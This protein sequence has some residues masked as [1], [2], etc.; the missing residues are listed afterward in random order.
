M[1]GNLTVEFYNKR[2][3]TEIVI[4]IVSKLAENFTKYNSKYTIFS[5]TFFSAETQNKITFHI[6]TK[7]NSNYNNV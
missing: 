3:K 6:N 5:T 4:V 7:K 2:L 1:Q